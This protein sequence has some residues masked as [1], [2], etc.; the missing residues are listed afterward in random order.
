MEVGGLTVVT[1]A[2]EFMTWLRTSS[3]PGMKT[4]S[5]TP[6]KDWRKKRRKA[7]DYWG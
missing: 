3:P 6:S 1:A 4:R 7:V 2:S 5:L